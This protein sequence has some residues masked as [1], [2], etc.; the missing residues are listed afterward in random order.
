[1]KRIRILKIREV[2]KEKKAR[3]PHSSETGKR[4]EMEKF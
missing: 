2:D 3:T 1:M 4:P